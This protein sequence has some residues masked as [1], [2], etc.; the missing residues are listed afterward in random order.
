MSVG[1]CGVRL[2][3]VICVLIVWCLRFTGICRCVL[4]GAC[5]LLACAVHCSWFVVR[6]WLLCCHLLLCVFTVVCKLVCVVCVGAVVCCLLCGTLLFVA[7]SPPYICIYIWCPMLFDV[8]RRSVTLLGVRGLLL[9]VG[10]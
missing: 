4:S 2:F 7:L 10:C 8:V 3:V 6:C 1:C 9:V 5:C